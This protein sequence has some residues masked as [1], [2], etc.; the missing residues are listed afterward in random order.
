MLHTTDDHAKRAWSIAEHESDDVFGEEE[1]QIYEQVL[2]EISG[3]VEA[4]EGV[5][6]EGK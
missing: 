6:D 1:H 5:S 3:P 4:A 2:R